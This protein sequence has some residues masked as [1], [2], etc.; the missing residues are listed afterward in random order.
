MKH[1]IVVY[2]FKSF[3]VLILFIYET[4]KT[5]TQGGVLISNSIKL[6]G[7]AP[8]EELNLTMDSVAKQFPNI[9]TDIYTADLSEGQELATKLYQNGYDAIISRGGTAKLIKETLNIPVIDVSISIYD[10]LKSIRLTENYTTQFVIVGY[11][12]I[13]EKAH[14][15]CDIMGYKIEIHTITNDH[16]ANKILDNLTAKHYDFIL[17]DAITNRLALSKSLNTILITSSSESIRQ[18]YEE[19]IASVQQIQT[20]KHKKDLFQH[21]ITIQQQKYLIFDGALSL[22]FSNVAKDLEQS[23][24][25]YL[26]SKKEFK[27][28]NQ[29]YITVQDQLYSLQIER[30]TVDKVTYYSCLVKLQP[31]PNLN[32]KLGI[33]Y[34]KQSTISEI[35]ST[36][37]LFK[38]YISEDTKTEINKYVQHYH[39][40]LVFG[41]TGTAKKNIAYQI[42]LNQ[43][44]NNNYLIAINCKLMSD[45]LWR[46]LVNSANGPLVNLSN[47]I[48]FEHIEQLTITD[49]ERLISLINNT[50]L[51]KSNTIIFTFNSNATTDS[52]KIS[53]LLNQLDSATIH[54]P[55]VSERKNELSII[56]TLILNKMNIE[57]GKEVLGFEPK[58]LQK[59]LDYDWPGNF[60]Q[61][62]HAIKELVINTVSHYISLQQ[63]TNLIDRENIINNVSMLP[64]NSFDSNNNKL[65]PTLF[66]YT[67]EII[68]SV[69][70]QNNGNQTKTAEQ[71][72]ISRTTLWR[73]LKDT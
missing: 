52:T 71:L 15:I 61:L 9:Q 68:R 1:I 2:N 47:T 18:A 49:I 56:A 65:Q 63:V 45:K 51:L 7:I 3:I 41:E 54:A 20:F 34:H 59:F 69:L 39:S 33:A 24:M 44:T 14:L 11:A 28:S 19:A 66:D 57:C 6:L 8:Y 12:S 17:C 53:I 43:Q 36:K 31:I 25:K 62:E 4:N 29:F 32:N 55:S 67:T 35:F 58:A 38:Q 30:F 46:S 27:Q 21:A 16:D 42:Y 37:L 13:T 5:L 40:F 23:I 72:D 70:E 26:K 50:N 73:Y 48:L 60:N 64:I 22:Q 10:I